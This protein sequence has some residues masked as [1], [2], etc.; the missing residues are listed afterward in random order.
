MPVSE[1]CGLRVCWKSCVQCA[2]CV[3]DSVGEEILTWGV[4]GVKWLSSEWN[5]LALLWLTL[6]VGLGLCVT[7]DCAG[8]C[9]EGEE[10]RGIAR[11]GGWELRQ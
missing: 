9:C 1:H 3:K 11:C 5:W 2:V 4:G 7:P 6:V 10:L 8:I